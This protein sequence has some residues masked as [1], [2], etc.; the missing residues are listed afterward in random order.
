MTDTGQFALDA[1]RVLIAAGALWLALLVAK[2]GWHRFRCKDGH[3]ADNVH[4]TTHASFALLLAA[5]AV[6][7]IEAV[8]QPLDTRFGV[9]LAAVGLGV[10]GVLKRTRLNWRPPHRR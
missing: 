8:G 2:L 7:R 5:V 1:G 4:W 3:C 10:Y 6:Y 9:T